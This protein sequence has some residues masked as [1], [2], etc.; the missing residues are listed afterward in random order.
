VSLQLFVVVSQEV[1]VEIFV[2]ES[3]QADKSAGR[4][5]FRGVDISNNRGT[6]W[7]PRKPL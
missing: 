6:N 3:L 2:D 5:H 4:N 7:N 1:V